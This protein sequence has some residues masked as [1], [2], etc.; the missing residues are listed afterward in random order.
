MPVSDIER[1][2]Q[3]YTDRRHRLSQSDKYSVFNASA[4]FAIH[5]R[6]HAM[7]RIFKEH[8][9]INLSKQSIIE[10]GCG[11]GGV[12]SE[13]HW[14]S[15]SPVNLTGVDLLLNR[16]VDARQNHPGSLFV[17]ANGQFL[18]YASHEFDIA[19]QFT[20]ISSILDD[21]IRRGVCLEMLRVIKP[22]GFILWYDFWLNPINRQTRGIRP[23]EIRHLF[24]HCTYEFHKITLAPPIARRVVP[25]SRTL[26]LILENL[27]IFNSH[28]LVAIKPN[29]G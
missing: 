13:L 23:A 8:G 28:Y 7:I 17:N 20:A 11:S 21:E 27:K 1:M 3:E 19:M 4:R 22:T 9:I 14:L 24:P 18:P 26:G 10:I 2:K 25:I 29:P 5:Q 12:M 16:L 6:Q 15:A